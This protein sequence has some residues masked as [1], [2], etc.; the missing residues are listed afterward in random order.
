MDLN[1]QDG[2]QQ[3][4][5]SDSELPE[6][7]EPRDNGSES[8]NGRQEAA[9]IL[10]GN[11]PAESGQLSQN[12][13]VPVPP[14]GFTP[15]GDGQPEAD[16]NARDEAE[17]TPEPSRVETIAPPERTTERVVPPQPKLKPAIPPPTTGWWWRK[18]ARIPT[19]RPFR[20]STASGR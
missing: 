2:Q 19:P 11:Q 4:G 8:D 7:P 6:P 16:P 15:P 9:D 13:G 1:S 5:E 10:R 3:A 17:S 14:P 18:R 20:P 12:F